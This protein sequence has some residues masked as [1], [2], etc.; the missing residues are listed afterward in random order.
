ML[1]V[2]NQAWNVER[3]ALRTGLEEAERALALEQNLC[4]ADRSIRQANLGATQE[5][6]MH[7]CSPYQSKVNLSSESEEQTKKKG[8]V[9]VDTSLV[10]YSLVDPRDAGDSSDAE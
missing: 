8:F 2:A 4:D 3:E 7:R 6:S 1:L 10:G 9:V 5:E